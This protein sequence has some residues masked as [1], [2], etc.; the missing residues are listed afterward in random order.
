MLTCIKCGTQNRDGETFCGR[1]GSFLEWT[2]RPDETG[3]PGAVL[4]QAQRARPPVTSPVSGPSVLADL[5]Q[6][7]PRV[8]PGNPA[9]FSVAVQN[10]GRTVDQVG[11]EVFGDLAPWARVQ[12]PSV[13]LLPEG[14]QS[15]G[16]QVLVPRSHEVPAGTYEIGLAVRSQEHPDQPVYLRT[17]LEIGPFVEYELEL[18]PKIVRA[19]HRGRYRLRATNTG[20]TPIAFAISGTDPEAVL[21]FSTARGDLVVAPGT[22]AAA[23]VRVTG[24]GWRLRGSQR[25]LPFQLSVAPSSG[26]KR[27]LDGVLNQTVVFHGLIPLMTILATAAVAAVVAIAALRPFGPGFTL[28]FFGGVNAA[29]VSPAPPQT[30]APPPTTA[31]RSE[32]PPPPSEAPP[33]EQPATEPPT[34]AP[35]DWWSDATGE[36]SSLGFDLGQPTSGGTTSEGMRYEDFEAGVVIE[37]SD[38]HYWVPQ[39]IRD[40]WLGL[41]GSGPDPGTLGYPITSLKPAKDGVHRRELFDNGSIYWDDR[42][43]YAIFGDLWTDLVKRL[44]GIDH[45]KGLN[46][47]IPDWVNYPNG[48]SQTFADGTALQTFQTGFTWIADGQSGWCNTQRRPPKTDQA[49]FCA[50]VVVPQFVPLPPELRQTPTPEPTPVP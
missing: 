43:T 19:R 10:T 26:P 21:R 41:G 48:D 13:N 24:P 32:Q 18:T 12:P 34:S 1:C 31:P 44:N 3:A 2:G 50:D 49:P 15:I 8:E 6:A 4:P 7:T 30:A 39:A 17:T 47:G 36:A 37:R 27:V 28:P 46:L 40:K 11:L 45:V 25:T 9:T 16:V 35:A 42:G 23:E 14:R 38:G 22:T 33:T 5:A 20:N 29:A